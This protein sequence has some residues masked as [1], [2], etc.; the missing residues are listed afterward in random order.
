MTDTG[1][2]VREVNL[3][4]AR[5]KATAEQSGSLD[6]LVELVAEVDELV[7]SFG[8]RLL[9]ARAEAGFANP[10]ISRAAREAVTMSSDAG[11]EVDRMLERRCR[12]AKTAVQVVNQLVDAANQDLEFDE[13]R[14]ES[15]KG[16]EEELAAPLLRDIV[17]RKRTVISEMMKFA[18]SSDGQSDSPT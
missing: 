10:V 17:T 7:R 15:I 6:T 12:R 9:A 3:A 18:A 11:R 14:L 16:P 5:E 4:Y 2:I 13:W 8:E 1:Y